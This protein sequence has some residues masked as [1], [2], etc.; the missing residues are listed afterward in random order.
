M[1]GLLVFGISEIFIWLFSGKLTGLQVLGGCFG[2]V[3]NGGGKSKTFPY[4]VILCNLNLSL[5]ALRN[6]NC[7]IVKNMVSATWVVFSRFGW[8]LG[9]DLR[10]KERSYNL[11]SRAELQ[12]RD[13]LASGW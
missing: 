6:T 5:S 10:L 3:F 9:T 12:S 11:D 1:R 7:I 2:F 13:S 8:W 4:M